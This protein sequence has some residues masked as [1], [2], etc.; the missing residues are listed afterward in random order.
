[1]FRDGERWAAFVVEGGRARLRR[2]EIGLM[3]EQFAEVRQ[4]LR[5]GEEV[6]LIPSEAVRDGVKLTRRSS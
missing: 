3:N 4:G 6:A 5:L 2:L 1:L